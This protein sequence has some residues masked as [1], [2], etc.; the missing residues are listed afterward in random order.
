MAI[1]KELTEMATTCLEVNG[2]PGKSPGILRAIDVTGDGV[3]DYIID[4]HAFNCEGAPNPYLTMDSDS[5]SVSIYV[6]TP[7]G[8]AIKVFSQGVSGIKINNKSKPAKLFVIVGGVL[9]GQRNAEKLTNSEIKSCWRPL[10]WNSTTQ[11]MDFAPISQVV[12]LSQGNK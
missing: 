12:F 6:G 11:K 7:D 9:C 3:L 5:G 4:S 10:I 1:K 8:Q 2:K